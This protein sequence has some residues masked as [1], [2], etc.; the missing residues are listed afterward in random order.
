MPSSTSHMAKATR[1]RH[2]LTLL[3]VS[4]DSLDREDN[5][6]RCRTARSTLQPHTA[7]QEC[8]QDRVG[9]VQNI[10]SFAV[11]YD[12]VWNQESRGLTRDGNSCRGEHSGIKV[13]LQPAISE[14]KLS[15]SFVS[16]KITRLSW[17]EYHISSDIWVDVSRRSH[18]GKGWSYS[19]KKRW[20]VDWVCPVRLIRGESAWC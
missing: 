14:S 9:G 5:L 12:D 18:T 7:L 10:R 17:V 16:A 4:T 13:A 15:C 19:P 1:P 6:L 8:Q 3:V 11:G 2:R 20:F